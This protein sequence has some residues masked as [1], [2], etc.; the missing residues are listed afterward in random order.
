MNCD[1]PHL[2]ILFIIGISAWPA[3]VTARELE[4]TG[5]PSTTSGEEDG[6]IDRISSE[7]T[8]PCCDVKY[9]RSSCH[10]QKEHETHIFFNN[11]FKLF[12][13]LSEFLLNQSSISPRTAL[14]STLISLPS[15]PFS[16]RTNAGL[17]SA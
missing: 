13:P 5:S 14:S 9:Q 10:R 16:L 6:I 15:P 4:R 1:R 7:N 3:R 2:A 8:S 12:P 11:P 17:S